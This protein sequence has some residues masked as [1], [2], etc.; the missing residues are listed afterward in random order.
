M[1]FNLSRLLIIKCCFGL[2]RLL[3]SSLDKLKQHVIISSLDKLKQHLIIS[4]L[5]KLK[6]HLIISSLDKLKQC[7]N[8]TRGSMQFVFTHLSHS[9]IKSFETIILLCRVFIH[10]ARQFANY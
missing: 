2:S 9:Y 10:M 3:I 7:D 4:S 5:D 1:L 8:K 6:Q